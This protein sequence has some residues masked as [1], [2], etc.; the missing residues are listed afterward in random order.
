MKLSGL[1]LLSFI[2]FLSN[3]YISGTG[4]FNLINEDQSTI[5]TISFVSPF[6]E[7]NERC[8]ICHGENNYEYENE[9]PGSQAKI[10]MSSER[11]VKREDFYQS[12]HKTFSCT[13]CHSDE[14][15][16]F[17]HSGELRMEQN[18]NCIDCH[19]GSETSDSYHFD[20]IEAEYQQSMH[21]KL[22]EYGFS[23]WKCHDPHSFKATI[24][25][26]INLKEIILYDNNICLDCHSDFNQFQLYSEREETDIE[27]SHKWLPKQANHFK[28]IRCI[29]C[30]TRVNDS[31]L[32]AH[33]ITP[34]E[35]AVRRCNECHSK[36]S[37]LMTTLY[38]F[39]S[40]EQSQSGFANG[41]ILNE[42][43]VIG[44]NRNR[45]LNILSQLIFIGLLILIAVHITFRIIKNNSSKQRR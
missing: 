2:F 41:I 18:I 22:E 7:D 30:H 28:S 1:L 12:N 43:Y 24:R 14:Y 38:K 8:F 45:Y 4:L 37:L 42:S 23:C 35:E 21:F 26:T 40:K 20:D 19:G 39:Q 29:E 13:G 31:I 3:T 9:I 33:L 36:N 44:A 10:L 27:K 15:I 32:V 25:N 11:Y 17:P 16:N 34:K 5:D 6:A